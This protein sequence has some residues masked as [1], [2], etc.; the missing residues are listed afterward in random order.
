MKKFPLREEGQGLVEYALI[1]VLVALVVIGILLMLGPV[2]GNVF[3]NVVVAF[4]G[5]AAS[6]PITSVSAQ[7]TGGGHGNDVV[8][9]VTVSTSTTLT[10]TDSQSGHSTNFTCS[11]TC[12]RTITGVG[13]AAGTIT[14]TGGGGTATAGYPA[15]L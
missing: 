4:Q 9:T 3:S 10:A 15:K 12:Q 7:R 11:G 2:V 1:L 5:V 14:V 8:V 6:G 13:D